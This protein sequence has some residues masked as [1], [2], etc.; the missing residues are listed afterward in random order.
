[1]KLYTKDKKEVSMPAKHIDILMNYRWPGNVRELQSALQRY[2]AVG[3]LDFLNKKDIEIVNNDKTTTDNNTTD[4][5]ETNLQ[6]A[7]QAFE[8]QFILKALNEHHWHRGK[9]ASKLGINPKTLYIK[10]KKMRLS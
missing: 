9:V 3:N 5:T 10:M 2:L 6:K 4:I 7:I 8:K 1:L